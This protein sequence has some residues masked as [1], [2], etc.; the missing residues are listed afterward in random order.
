MMTHTDQGK[1]AADVPPR[2]LIETACAHLA[3]LGWTA[4]GD[5]CPP[6]RLLGGGVSNWVI[7]FDVGPGVVVKQALAQL[8]VRE[9]WLA[10]PR[11][12]V[13]EGYAMATLGERLPEGDVPRVLFVDEDACLL[14][15][16][17]APEQAK[18]WKELLLRGEADPR[19]ARAVGALLGRM[20]RAAWSDPE[21]AR[22]YA[23]LT[24]FEQLRLDPYHAYTARLAEQRGDH[25]LAASLRS[26]AQAM[27]ENRQTLVHGDFSPKNLLVWDQSVLAL[28]FEV[29]HWGNPDFDT[30]FLLTH[31][32]LKG[33]HR[34]AA[35]AA[36]GACARAFLDA[37]I[38][39]LGLQAAEVVENGALRQAGCLLSAR[40][41]G[42][43]P[44]E[45]LS[46]DGRL[47]ARALGAAVLRGEVHTVAGLF[48][49][50]E[51][52]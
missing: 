43:S 22:R 21:L 4:P 34:P 11:R 42:K 23:D 13:L 5:A 36:C 24:L 25:D 52:S 28:D 19:T 10:D 40:A 3:R 47:R 16:S 51:A 38:A 15:M 18:P 12:A 41:D 27:R 30:A 9:E 45:Y 8:R 26:G 6:W 33:I 20:H 31:L 17:A 50:R 7:R 39:T 29:V 32:A 2:S 14:G 48:S 44:A 46:P 49:S 1:D 35:A 37:Y